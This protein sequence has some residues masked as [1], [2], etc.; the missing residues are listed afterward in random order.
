MA[1]LHAAA[2]P[3]AAWLSWRLSGR[4]LSAAVVGAAVAL[5]PG[6]LDT[7]HS[8]AEGYLAPVFLGGM[9]L[10]STAKRPW[11]AGLALPVWAA[12]VMHHP[13]ALAAAPL[14]LGVQWR[15]TAVRAGAGV[16][17]LMLLPMGLR[18]MSEGF[19]GGAGQ[20]APL[21]APGA[22]LAQGGPLAWIVLLGPFLG[23]ISPRTRQVAIRTLATLALLGALGLF[24]GYL[25]D[26][27][28]RLLTIP[29]IVGWAA[30]P[31]PGLAA[32][33]VGMLWPRG[34]GSPADLP[35]QPGTLGLARAMADQV[36]AEVAPPLVVD[37][38]WLSGGPAASPAAIMLDLHLRG[39]TARELD[40]G[41]T[42]VVIVSADRQAIR[43]L[44][45]DGLRMLQGERHAL[46]IG[47]PSEVRPWSAAHCGGKLGGA[48]DALSV[49]H[50]DA[51]VDTSRGWWAC[52]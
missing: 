27:H 10:L 40:T 31:W 49:L 42:V 37:G 11:L 26:H 17:L 16:A 19:P 12:A 15:H 5:D 29:A 45:P 4:H 33:V 38:A 20:G 13:A 43:G 2:A 41:H 34:P 8:G 18:M 6:L 44:S 14:L 3:L 7:V 52:P 36:A 48:W 51:T 30:V 23:L 1:V 32:I 46:L 35:N 25:R 9:V 39:W 50:P 22:Y 24:G 21:Q 47:Q 28:L